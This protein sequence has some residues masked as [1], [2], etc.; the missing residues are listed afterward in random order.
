MRTEYSSDGVIDGPS[1]PAEFGEFGA[2]AVEGV[3]AH[4][5]AET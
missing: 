1:V 4:T 5:S 2:G 3:N